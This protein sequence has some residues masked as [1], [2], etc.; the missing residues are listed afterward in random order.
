MQILHS[1]CATEGLLLLG[2]SCGQ[3]GEGAA[4][5]EFRFAEKATYK[6]KYSHHKFRPHRHYP[7]PLRDRD[8][9]T[10][11]GDLGCSCKRGKLPPPRSSTW[12]CMKRG[13]R[14]CSW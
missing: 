5:S 8:G 7:P 3:K 10:S 12:S 14:D 9:C 6:G 4:K 1:L 11:H 2:S 13:T